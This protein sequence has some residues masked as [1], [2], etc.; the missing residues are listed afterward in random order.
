MTAVERHALARRCAE[1]ARPLTAATT[2]SKAVDARWKA[3]VFIDNVAYMHTGA[4]PLPTVDYVHWSNSTAVTMVFERP[5]RCKRL[6][7][8]AVDARLPFTVVIRHD[9]RTF[10]SIIVDPAVENCFKSNAG[11]TYLNTPVSTNDAS[12]SVVF[13]GQALHSVVLVMNHSEF[14]HLSRTFRLRRL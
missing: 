6:V 11:Y 13:D 5:N 9:G 8:H 12:V 3:S 2:P 4:A 14:M 10:A 1:S 7:D